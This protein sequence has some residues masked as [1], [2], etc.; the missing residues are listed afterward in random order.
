MEATLNHIPDNQGI[1]LV[2]KFRLVSDES[3]KIFGEKWPRQYY[4]VNHAA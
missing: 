4:T 1:T 2:E 3:N